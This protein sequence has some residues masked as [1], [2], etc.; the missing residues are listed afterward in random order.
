[1]P[2]A[3]QSVSGSPVTCAASSPTASCPSVCASGLTDTS[4][5]LTPP[6]TGGSDPS[7]P[8]NPGPTGPITGPIPGAVSSSQSITESG[9]CCAGGAC[10][11]AAPAAM[12][13]TAKTAYANF[14]LPG[15]ELQGDANL[16]W[17]R[18]VF[19][20]QQRAE[21]GIGQE[22]EKPQNNQVKQ[23]LDKSPHVLPAFAL[24]APS[25]YNWQLPEYHA[26]QAHKGTKPQF[27]AD[28]SCMTEAR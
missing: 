25:L 5:V 9:V 14:R 21:I 3:D 10:A 8:G 7:L 26:I 22:P 27:Y 4:G 6:V 23:P 12:Q 20:V 19:T 15:I 17:L 24:L 1:M 16:L 28:G 13:A 11:Y 18:L 2:L